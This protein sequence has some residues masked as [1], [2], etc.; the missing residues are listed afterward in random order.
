MP[1]RSTAPTSEG[2]NVPKPDKTDQAILTE[3]PSSLWLLLVEDD[4]GDQML[5]QEILK[6]TN[7]DAKLTLVKDGE[8]AVHC[9]ERWSE[10]NRPDLVLLDL[11][12]PKM[13]AREVLAHIRKKD[14]TVRV[15]A[16][17]GFG[18]QSDIAR[19]WESQ[20]DGYLVKPIGLDELSRT[21]ERLRMLMQ[22]I[23]V[24]E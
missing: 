19:E 10:S 3:R 4:P 18:L 24:R 14:P 17:T 9:I 1:D 20:V 23:P 13:D 11:N 16:L 8:K 21:A 2:R 6:E 5:V 22:S 7:L 12:L 15:A